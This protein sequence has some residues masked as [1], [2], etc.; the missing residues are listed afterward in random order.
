M[1]RQRLQFALALLAVLSF[2]GCAKHVNSSNPAVININTLADAEN[3]VNAI[4]HGLATANATLKKLQAAEPDYYA[5]AHPKLLQIAQLNEKANA[6]IVTAKNGNAT[7]DWKS[8]VVAVGQ[9]VTDPSS[10]TTFGFKNPT[11]Q[12]IVQ[13]SFSALVAGISLAATY[14]GK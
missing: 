4:S 2:A 8:A 6:A 3:T 10:L 1:K 9:V 14:G 11:T 12:A 5:Y 7:V 13:D